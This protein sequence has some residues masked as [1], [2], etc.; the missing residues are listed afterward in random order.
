MPKDKLKIYSLEFILLVVLSFTLFVPKIYNKNLLAIL[1][2]FFS[3]IACCFIKRK[4]TESINA[5]KVNVILIIFG[6]I[7]LVAFYLM[8]LYFDYYKTVISFSFKTVINYII[9]ISAII[10]TSEIIRNIFLSQNTKFTSTIITII[11][12]I[13]DLVI[14][15]DVYNL[16]TYEKIIETITF[17]FFASVAC[18]LLYN[19]ISKR[20]GYKG[21]IFYRLI[22]VLYVYIIPYI[23]NV[24]VF[25]RAILRIIYPYIIYSVIEYTFSTS[26]KVVAYEDKRKNFIGKI[27]LGILIV[28]FAMLVSCKYRYGILVMGSGSMTGT[29]NKGDA[30]IFEQYNKSMDIKEGQI[31]IFNKDE[32]K[33]VHRVVDARKVNGEKRYTTKGDVNSEN[34][35]GYVTLDSLMGIYKFKIPFIG[36]PTIWIRD[37]L[38]N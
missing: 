14:Y 35:D 32:L 30:I 17:I 26:K 36:Y 21:I 2:T 6:V 29:I 27:I 37:I 16:N 15:V 33:I 20:Y 5:N 4:T 34:D 19:Y 1:L 18:N 13:I 10:I 7:Y 38:S 12:V 24:Y 3:I 9:P 31:I 28:L 22:T 25:F 8:G 23:P 11:M